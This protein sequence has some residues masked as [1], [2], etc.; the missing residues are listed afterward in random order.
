MNET[1]DSSRGLPSTSV[2]QSTEKW[3]AKT[4]DSDSKPTRRFGTIRPLYVGSTTQAQ[5]RP[6]IVLVLCLN[7]RHHS[8]W[9]QDRLALGG[10]SPEN[11]P[12]GKWGLKPPAIHEGSRPLC[13]SFSESALVTQYQEYLPRRPCWIGI[14]AF[15]PAVDKRNLQSVRGQHLEGACFEGCLNSFLYQT[16]WNSVG[17]TAH[18]KY[19][20]RYC[21]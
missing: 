17:R 1:S 8:G 5:W 2:V 20:V 11:T 3:Q 15:Y 6:W 21:I 10:C 18:L 14:P 16:T 13:S 7:I 4:M 9:C 19:M 12:T